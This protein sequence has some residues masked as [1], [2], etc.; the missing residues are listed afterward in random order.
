MR[1][2]NPPAAWTASG[3]TLEVTAAGGTDFWRKT[4][5]GFVRDNGHFYHQEVTGDFVAET[6]VE[7]AYRAR[8][9][10]AGLMVRADEK[11]WLKCGVEL[12]DGVQQASVVVTRDYSDWSVAPLPGAPPSTRVRVIR[13]GQDLEVQHS[14]GGEGWVTIRTARLP[15]AET[16]SVGVMC[17]SPDGDGFRAVFRGYAVRMP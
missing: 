16:V 11:T 8:Y 7:G 14:L 10:Q 2:L 6:E 1:W 17:A 4:H 12:V 5:Y 13:R 15:M 9:D 3:D